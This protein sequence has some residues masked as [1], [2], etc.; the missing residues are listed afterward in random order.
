MTETLTKPAEQV[1]RDRW[2]RPMVIPPGGGK[3]IAYRRVTTF[4]DVLDDR[5][6]LELWKQRQV[7]HG[8]AM[9]PDL[10]LKA[11]SANGD[12]KLLNEVAQTATEAAG[13]TQA[14]TTGTALHA[15]T[16]QLDRGQDPLIPPSAQPDVDAYRKATEHLEMRL[17]EVFVVHDKLQVGGTFDRVVEVD[18]QRYV[19]DIK[20]GKIDYGHGK[21]AMQLALYSRSQRYRVD[22]GAREPLDV[23]TSRGLVI[24]LPAGAGEC[25][26]HWAELDIG[27]CGV[28]IAK[29]VWDWRGTTGLLEAEPPSSRPAASLDYLISIATNRVELENLFHRFE[30]QW[31]EDHTD[32]ARERLIVLASI[33]RSIQSSSPAPA[34]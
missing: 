17:I 6:A 26:L 3:K 8:M 29:D 23:D 27:W 32:A 24:H 14:A 33:K 21:I 25:T 16:E 28:Q 11:A 2:G 7:A 20:T 5:F 10:V 18:G 12:K 22:G 9:R 34:A 4:I 19:A 15:I 13:S 31:T 1:E 30:A